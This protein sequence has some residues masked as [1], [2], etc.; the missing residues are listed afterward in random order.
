MSNHSA[1]LPSTREGCR[2]RLAELTADVVAIKT[3]IAT[4]DLE[5]QRRRGTVDPARFQECRTALRDK[6][7]EI[8][9]ITRHMATLPSR[10]D[11]LKDRL[12]EVLRADYDDPAWQ[13]AVD[14]AR[15]LMEAKDA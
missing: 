6:Q 10:R 5:R 1:D 9:R 11:A 3:R 15:R 4:A 13:A 2:T 12:I 8:Q 7:R 14:R